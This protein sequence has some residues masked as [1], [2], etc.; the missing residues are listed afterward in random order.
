MPYSYSSSSWLLSSSD[1]Q[2]TRHHFIIITLSTSSL[3]LFALAARPCREID[4]AG[5]PT[6]PPPPDCCMPSSPNTN[7]DDPTIIYRPHLASRCSNVFY[8]IF[9]TQSGTKL[10]P[11]C[12]ECV[13]G[14]GSVPARR[15]E[16]ANLTRQISL[17]PPL[18]LFSTCADSSRQCPL[19]RPAGRCCSPRPAMS[20]RYMANVGGDDRR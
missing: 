15:V 17:S 10:L 1:Y 11:I 9:L 12:L 14:G 19:I 4:Q 8:N 20:A 3:L 6:L 2:K 13:W 7:F 18:S 16:Q 5:T